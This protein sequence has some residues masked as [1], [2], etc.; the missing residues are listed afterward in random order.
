MPG[1]GLEVARGFA[2]KEPG[3]EIPG[4]VRPACAQSL[5]DQRQV[6][7]FAAAVCARVHRDD[8]LGE[9]G[10][11]ARHPDHKQRPSIMA[12]DRSLRAREEARS[13]EHTSELQSLMR[14]SYAVFC[15]NK[16]KNQVSSQ[17]DHL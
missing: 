2:F 17:T 4:D 6:G 16:T 15:L 14:T 10:P 9:R 7:Q 8:L 13:E 12:A 3:F 11:A 1:S 5:D